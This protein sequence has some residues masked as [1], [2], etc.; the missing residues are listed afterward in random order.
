MKSAEARDLGRA[1]GTTLGQLTDLV[2]GA[3][4][5]IS[6]TVHAALARTVGPTTLPVRVAH[7]SITA[8]AYATVGLS[9]RLASTVAGHAVAHR[10][11]DDADRPSVHDGKGAH[12]ALAISLGL[13]GDTFAREAAS[14]APEMQIRRSGQ[15][16]PPTPAGIAD[17]FA[18]ATPDIVVFLHGLFE[19]E[20]AWHLRA[21]ELTPYDARLRDELGFTPVMIRYN[22]GLRVSENAAALNGLLAD[23]VAAWP[24]PPRR[25][26]L[27]GHSM[28]GLIIH[29]ALTI[30]AL[31]TESDASIDEA[32]PI[33]A[34]LGAH[35]DADLAAHAAEAPPSPWL[36]LVTD[37]VSLGT[38][39]HGS[40]IARVVGDSAERLDRIDQGRFIS[41]FLRH[42]AVSLR[43]LH[44]GNIVEADWLDHDLDDI[45][46]RRTHPAPVAGPRHHAVV[47]IATADRLPPTLAEW[48]GD[49][50]VSSH[51]ASHRQT[52]DETAAERWRFADERIAIVPGIGHFG[53]LNNDRVY[54]HLHAWLRAT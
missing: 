2:R 3:H 29:G 11:R 20:S 28:G 5:A 38:P 19:T 31:A 50:V 43:D 24:M 49:F 53:L 25:I 48:L 26:V 14:L 39:H 21:D 22:T 23:L 9:L 7:D 40:S 46:D 41:Q 30:A 44:H 35:I 16:V 13:R 6:D 42:R 4:F 52:D 27:I 47:A 17:A 33:D 54:A 12:G 1:A 37:T 36:G 45:S 32:L 51:S 10:L 8:G 34:E 15:R 18:G